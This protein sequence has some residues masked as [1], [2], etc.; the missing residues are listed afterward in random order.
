MR[1]STLYVFGVEHIG[2]TKKI[3]RKE[4]EDKQ[5]VDDIKWKDDALFMR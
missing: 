3:V 1:D 4:I 5:M 2:T